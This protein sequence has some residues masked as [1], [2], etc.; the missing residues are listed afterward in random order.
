M[1]KIAV[2]I[3]NWNGAK[4]LQQFLPSVIKYTNNELAEIIVA[5]NGSTDD[6][7]NVLE[8]EFPDIKVIKFEKNYGFT[9]GYNKA[10]ALCDHKYFVLLNSDIEVTPNWVDI[11]YK[12][13]EADNQV[14]ACQPKLLAYHDKNSFEYAGAAGGFIDKYGYPFCRGRILST[15]EKDEGQYDTPAN[16]Q[17]ATGACLM[18]QSSIYKK[19]GGLDDN[20]FAHME[21][22][23]LC[24]RAK[25]EGYKI[26]VYPESKIYHVGGGTL[27]NNSP[28][29]LFLNYRN[30]LLLL[31][32]NLPKSKLKSTL[33][34]RFRFDMMSA[35]M[36]AM[37]FQ[38]SFMV[39]V[40]KARKAYKKLKPL[41]A[42]VRQK[43]NEHIPD[44]FPKEIYGKS[45]IWQYFL[46]GRKKYSQLD[47][48]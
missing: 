43:S 20:F 29:K 22:I 33:R 17:W 1:N 25:N 40:F 48:C 38:F 6:S 37:K 46:K 32:K 45:I 9:G 35:G 10:L 11:L 23:D 36:Y 34:K 19:L 21:E 39:Q 24:W 27:P 47:D 31:Y 41:Y 26:M 12:E 16:I 4:M 3:L 28:R 7:L 44:Q 42:E 2:V 5:D 30:N 15:V 8:K 13:M 14:A 18:I